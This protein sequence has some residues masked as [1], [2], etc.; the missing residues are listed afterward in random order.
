MAIALWR[1][2]M[3]ESLNYFPDAYTLELVE[4]AEYGRE[5]TDGKDRI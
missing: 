5:N 3:K 1:L 4:N 2:P